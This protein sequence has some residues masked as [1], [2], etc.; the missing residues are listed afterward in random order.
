F[1]LIE[2]LVVIAII[3]LLATTVMISLRDSQREARD[4]KRRADITTLM[5]GLNLY[6]DEN[7]EYPQSNCTEQNGYIVCLSADA[8]GTPSY[9]I[10]D[11][12]GYMTPPPAD[13]GKH[14]NPN[15]DTYIYL[16]H[17]SRQGYDLYFQL[18]E[19][20]Q[21]DNCEIGSI[22]FFPPEPSETWSTRCPN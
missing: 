7:D 13:P 16:V 2:L 1:T 8:I 12:Q 17:A 3:S 19:G 11:L 15:H 18:E 6:F 21:E 5:T 14:L 4:A 22:Q 20:P 9:W 10:P